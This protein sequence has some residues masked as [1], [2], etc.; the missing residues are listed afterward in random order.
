M[1]T[2]PSCT[3]CGRCIG[4]V[5]RMTP[6]RSIVGLTHSITTS[7]TPTSAG[8]SVALTRGT[9][10]AVGPSMRRPSLRMACRCGPRAMK[11]TSARRP[12]GGPRSSRPSRP[13]PSP[14]CAWFDPRSGGARL[15]AASQA[16]AGDGAAETPRWMKAC[17][18]KVRSCFAV[19][20]FVA[21]AASPSRVTLGWPPT[22]TPVSN[23][24]RQSNVGFA[25]A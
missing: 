17:S 14:Q 20:S 3:R 8:S 10:R 5:W 7:T 1:V 2:C 19:S 13:N 9:C 18:A 6:G 15:R 12:P 24:A 21:R 23:L 25:M 11:Y 16:R 22:T 4:P